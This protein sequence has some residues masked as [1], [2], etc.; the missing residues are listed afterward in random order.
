MSCRDSG[1]TR[2]F[3]V[4]DTMGALHFTESSLCGMGALCLK[5]LE[6]NRGCFLSTVWE[7]TVRLKEGRK[8]TL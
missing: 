3:S 8:E 4:V 2:S 7:G 5:I 1:G 6:A